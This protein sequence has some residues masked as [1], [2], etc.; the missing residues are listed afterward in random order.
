MSLEKLKELNEK[1]T[2]GP[3]ASCY[4]GSSTWSIGKAED[5]QDLRVAITER[6]QGDWDAGS[7]NAAFIA[8]SANAMPKLL[9]IVEAAIRCRNADMKGLNAVVGEES[10]AVDDL[11][12]ALKALE[13]GD[14]NR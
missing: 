12:K 3:W 10:W 13:E 6:Y 2:P 9:A 14:D 5:P 7:N 4:D 11:D 8:A 1:R